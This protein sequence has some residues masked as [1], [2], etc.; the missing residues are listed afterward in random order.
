MIMDI[1]CNL[2]RLMS[3]SSS[4]PK[5]E[6]IQWNVKHYAYITIMCQSAEIWKIEKKCYEFL[7][8]G[9]ELES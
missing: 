6:K 5:R 1:K 7:W 2:R 3:L 4:I 9:S 8:H